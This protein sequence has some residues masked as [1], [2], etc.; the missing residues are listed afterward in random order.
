MELKN[1]VTGTD[2]HLKEFIDKVGSEVL[3]CFDV[4]QQV[5]FVRSLKKVIISSYQIK[6]EHAAKRLE[7]AKHEAEII[8]EGTRE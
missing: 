1:E 2:E 3:R 4:D 6:V 8:I 7:E 5:E